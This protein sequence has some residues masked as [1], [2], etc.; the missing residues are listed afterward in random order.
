VPKKPKQFKRKKH[1]IHEFVVAE[2]HFFFTTS[3]FT[4]E[5]GETN[6]ILSLLEGA[7]ARVLD[8]VRAKPSRRCCLVV[9]IVA[10]SFTITT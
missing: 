9:L 6:E 1:A 2:C 5:K 8:H 3:Q 10:V 7:S 4:Q